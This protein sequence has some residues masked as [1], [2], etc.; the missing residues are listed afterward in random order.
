MLV[1]ANMAAPSALAVAGETPAAA[2]PAVV[3][4]LGKDLDE[5]RVDG[6]SVACGESLEPRLQALRQAEGDPRVVALV[7]RSGRRPL[8]VDDDELGLATGEAH[9]HVR[10][11]ELVAELERRLVQGLEQPAAERRVERS[12]SRRAACATASSP[13]AATAARS[14]RSAWTY[15]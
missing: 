8:V 2:V 13:T 10:P 6:H 15:P 12:A 1:T 14:S 4:A 11:V 5:Q 9:L 3:G 7:R